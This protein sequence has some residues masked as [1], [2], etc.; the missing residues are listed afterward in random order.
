MYSFKHA[1]K[2][3]TETNCGSQLTAHLPNSFKVGEGAVFFLWPS[4]LCCCRFDAIASGTAT[5][6][7]VL[8]KREL[9]FGVWFTVQH[10]RLPCITVWFTTGKFI[11][12]A[13]FWS[14]GATGQQTPSQVVDDNAVVNCDNNTAR[15]VQR[16][17][18]ALLLATL[19]V[20]RESRLAFFWTFPVVLK[21]C[22]VFV[23]GLVSFLGSLF[24]CRFVC[25]A[26]CLFLKLHRA[27]A[28]WCKTQFGH[29]FSTSLVDLG[30]FR[31][32]CFL[33]LIYLLFFVLVNS[34][35]KG[36]LGLF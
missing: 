16:H 25:F 6:R 8:R 4:T 24:A 33:V 14:S 21:T 30:L 36:T 32:A 1:R 34:P 19:R 28:L 2:R 5:R 20:T 31:F 13:F 12:S 10:Y 18:L 29:V 22:E 35:M 15:P 11:E 26:N 17:R 7:A 23:F 9:P 27:F 3:E